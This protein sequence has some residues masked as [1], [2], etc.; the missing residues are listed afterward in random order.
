MTENLS[1]RT[2]HG[3]KW[4]YLATVVNAALQIAVT[5]ALARLLTPA[6]F[7]LVAMASLVLRFGQYF[8]Q[9]GVGQ[10]VVQRQEITREHVA[11]GFWTSTLLGLAFWVGGVAFAPLFADLF[12]APE[13]TQVVQV[14]AVMFFVT[15]TSTIGL[16]ILR[17]AMRFRAI[18]AVEVC[19]YAVGYAVVGITFAWAGAGVWSLVAAGI[20]QAAIASVLYNVL[21]RPRIALIR[22]WQPYRDLLGFGSTVSLVTFLEFVNANLDTLVVGRVGGAGQLGLYSRALHVTSVPMEYMSRSLSKVL[23]PSFARIQDELARVGRAYVKVLTVFAGLGLPVA[24]GMAGAARE[25]VL[26]LL[27]SQWTDAIPV[28]R[29]VAVA[30]CAAMM[31][32][33]AGV[34]LE[35]TAH[36]KEKLMMRAGQLVLFGGALLLLAPFGL[37]G[38]ATAFALSEVALHVV[39]S[40]TVASR[41]QISAASMLRSYWP[42]IVSGLLCMVV[43]FAESRAGLYWG[44]PSGVV[45]A[46]QVATG[47]VVVLTVTLRLGRGRVFKLFTGLLEPKSAKTLSTRIM[48]RVA[49]LSG[50]TLADADMV[51]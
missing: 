17:R 40:A 35:A 20:T 28:V 45:L 5:A 24:L 42:G 22:H 47:V 31:S 50:Q 4:T 29:I 26:V 21:A 25:I 27:G 14:M 16:A 37:V 43:M 51:Q 2:V 44:M 19:S 39:V 30:A 48:K 6:A 15:G 34:A 1:A 7:G 9:M 33:F 10:A 41:Y 12:K 23:L 32:H 46:A 36:L 49:W 11:A 8:A 38:F 13:V 3:A 18:A